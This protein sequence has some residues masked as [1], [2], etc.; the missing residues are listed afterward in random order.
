MCWH[1][2]RKYED[3]APVYEWPHRYR[4][5]ITQKRHAN[6]ADRIRLVAFLFCNGITNEKDIM[7]IMK[8]KLRDKSALVHLKS[9]ISS[10]KGN[11]YD[12]KWTYYS[13]KD[14]CTLYLDGTL[15]TKTRLF[16]TSQYKNSV[17]ERYCYGSINKRNITHQEQLNFFGEDENV[18]RAI[19]E[20]IC[21]L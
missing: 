14:K 12:K 3:V 7:C 15:S 17:W 4:V 16:S 2:L 5:D 1:C 19:E 6:R 11:E 13:L 9:I 8:N 10:V 20:K 21:I 18:C